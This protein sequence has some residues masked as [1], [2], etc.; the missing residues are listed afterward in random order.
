MAR[1]LRRLVWVAALIVTTPPLCPSAV[2][3]QNQ[4]V[5]FPPF[6]CAPA[7]SQLAS[8]L[9]D[10]TQAVLVPFLREHTS[11]V[12]AAVP[13]RTELG[14][15][16]DDVSLG[17][18]A[19]ALNVTY[20]VVG[21]ILPI[22]GGHR[23]VTI[24]VYS[25]ESG[26]LVAGVTAT[27]TNPQAALEGIDALARRLCRVRYFVVHDVAM[28]YSLFVP[29]SGQFFLGEPV[30]AI[31]SAGAVL[32]AFLYRGGRQMEWKY[33][34][35]DK[36]W[37]EELATNRRNWIIL[38]WLFNVFDTVMVIQMKKSEAPAELFFYILDGIPTGRETGAC[39]VPMIGLCIPLFRR[40]DR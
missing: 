2:W 18:Y 23:T 4:M 29:G 24:G 1:R 20:L 30:H 27:F 12:V 38:A 34:Q 10:R 14:I 7:D 28:L 3:A 33:P 35:I 8:Q 22:Q 39:P 16:R 6:R 31:V 15:L 17:L 36:L 9:H 40:R 26:G 37:K 32:A 25:A 11:A 19:R 21:G 13:A 5:G